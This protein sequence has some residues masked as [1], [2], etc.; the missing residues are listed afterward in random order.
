[1]IPL[2]GDVSFRL[3]ADKASLGQL[4]EKMSSQGLFWAAW[5]EMEDTSRGAFLSYMERPGMYTLGGYIKEDLAGCLTVQPFG[6]KTLVAEIGVTAFRPYFGIARPLFLHALRHVLDT[7]DPAPS[8]FVGR[9]ARVNRHILA[10]LEQCGF[11]EMGRLPGLIWHARRGVFMEG[12]LVVA[13]PEKILAL[14]ED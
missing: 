5:P 1:M 6:E 14:L 9:V 10:M 13:Y 4:H 8:A 3:L 7:L 2:P 11:H 12:A